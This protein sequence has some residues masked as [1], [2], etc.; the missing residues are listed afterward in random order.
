MNKLRRLF[1][2]VSLLLPW[3]LASQIND[4]PKPLKEI[5]QLLEQKYHYQFTYAD[6]I[7]EAIV[8]NQFSEKLSLTQSVD[9]IKSQTHLNFKFLEG[10]IISIYPVKKINRICGFILDKIDQTPLPGVFV[11]TK[12]IVVYTD[13][14][15]FFEINNA[16]T[17]DTVFINLLGYRS[18][19]LSVKEFKDRHCKKFFLQPKAENLSTVVLQNLIAKGIYK[20]AGGQTKINVQKFGILPGLVEPDILQ[21]IQALPGIQSVNET[22]SYINIRGGTNDQNLLLWDGVRMYQ[23]GHFFGLISAFNPMITSNVTIIKDGTD[24]DL[25]NAVSGTISMHSEATFNTDFKAN[26]GA[27]FINADIFTDIPVNKR[28]SVQLGFRKAISDWFKTPTYD[29]YYKKILQNTEIVN[30]PSEILYSN[31]NFDFYDTSLRWLYQIT[32]QDYLR[33]NFIN[34]ADQFEFNKIA[35]IDTQDE[36][37]K[38]SLTQNNMAAGLFYKREWNPVFTTQ[39]QIYETDYKLKAI[40]SDLLN[41]QRI[42]QENIVSETGIKFESLYQFNKQTLLTGGYQFLENGTGNLTDIDNPIIFHFDREVI[43]EH[44]LFSQINLKAFDRKIDLKT[45]IRANYIVKFDKFLIE[46][47]LGVNYNISRH[48]YLEFLSEF[49]HQTIS[50][51]INLQNDFLGIEKRRWRLSNDK[52]VPIIQSKS[53]SFALNFD[54]KG[55]LISLETY[56]K[57]VNGIT[58]QSQGFVNQYMYAKA[59]GSFL[60]KGADI[61][62]NKRTT[63]FSTWL[64]Y[65]FAH[66][67]YTFRDFKEVHFP[68]NINISHN[69]KWGFSY[70]YKN[71]KTS[72]GLSWHTG[73]PTTVPVFGNE[74]V[75]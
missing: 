13:D 61:L 42:L 66:N 50:Q 8:I 46:P 24:A 18:L 35:I 2:I 10:N 6:D 4:G 74:I 62:I 47:R 22:V 73:K 63:N 67:V 51:I 28:S 33:L 39:L 68:N 48:L 11:Q 16:S 21:T 3:F 29:Q 54:K 34:I 41:N 23:S 43:R 19:F 44:S 1:I 71:F 25:G 36:N 38:S 37:K 45:G 72:L 12:K 40:N 69:I 30:H 55:W 20:E 60:V 31:I 14:K 64:S 17:Q 57:N 70:D 75:D 9:L 7:V 53:V 32:D 5:L 15:G 59:I 27:N 49:K 52:D 58:S 26:L 56:L 65:S